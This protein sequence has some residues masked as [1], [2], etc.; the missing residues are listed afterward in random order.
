[1]TGN[2]VLDDGS[3]DAPTLTITNGQDASFVILKGDSADTIISDTDKI[4]IKPK[5]DNDDFFEFA[6]LSNVPIFRAV[7]ANLQIKADGGTIDFDNENLI[8]TGNIRAGGFLSSD[9]STGWTGTCP[10]ASSTVVKQGI[11]TGCE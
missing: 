8:T 9:G 3:G 1:M 7:G 6:T 4:A 5:G 2:L 10:A 11:I